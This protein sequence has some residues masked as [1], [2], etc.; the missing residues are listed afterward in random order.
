MEPYSHDS[1]LNGVAMKTPMKPNFTVSHFIKYMIVRNGEY[2]LK[3]G[4]NAEYQAH[5]LVKLY[6]KHGMIGPQDE[7]EVI[8]YSFPNPNYQGIDP[9]IE[10]YQFKEL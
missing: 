2:I 4:I 8:R 1:V 6:Y 3:R 10:I 7:V 5:G 9:K